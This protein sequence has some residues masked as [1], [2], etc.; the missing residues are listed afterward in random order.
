MHY[1]RLCH[2][3][4]H[5]IATLYCALR[6]RFKQ[7]I[8]NIAAS[9]ETND[10]LK[11]KNDVR[12]YVLQLPVTIRLDILDM[13]L[14]PYK[15]VSKMFLISCEADKIK[16]DIPLFFLDVL[17]SENMDCVFNSYNAKYGLTNILNS[18]LQYSNKTRVLSFPNLILTSSEVTKVKCLINDVILKNCSFIVHLNLASCCTDNSL[19]IVGE[20]CYNLVNLAIAHSAVTDLGIKFLTQIVECRVGNSV[21]NDDDRLDEAMPISLR[22]SPGMSKECNQNDYSKH[23]CRYLCYKTKICQSLRY[24]NLLHTDVTQVSI[25]ILSKLVEKIE[26]VFIKSDDVLDSLHRNYLGDPLTLKGNA[27]KFPSLRVEVV[28]VPRLS[29]LTK[30]L[31]FNTIRDVCMKQMGYLNPN[32]LNVLDS[33]HAHGKNLHKLKLTSRSKKEID[34]SLILKYC[35]K[36]ETMMLFSDLLC[37]S[38]VKKPLPSPNLRYAS[39]LP[40]MDAHT[41]VMLLESANQLR[42]VYLPNILNGENFI[43]TLCQRNISNH[44]TWFYVPSLLSLGSEQHISQFLL[45]NTNIRFL[46]DLGNMTGTASSINIDMDVKF[47]KPFFMSSSSH[48]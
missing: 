45:R 4:H 23:Q 13:V 48:F 27:W 28:T 36:L 14:C 22:L 34:I 24:L 12:Q 32:S 30:L 18:L 21:E 6:H 46:G 44:L 16:C 40:H 33:L 20:N 9:L 39:M 1:F 25:S 26:N 31:S 15:N 2:V 42:E 10:K 35:P 5:K 47:D 7:H 8:M 19:R 17:F 29:M 11:V 37:W 38:N 41:A 3:R 43:G